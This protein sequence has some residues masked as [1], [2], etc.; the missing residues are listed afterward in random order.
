MP[1]DMEFQ[2]PVNA[3]RYLDIL[4]DD[5]N[6]VKYIMSFFQS[7]IVGPP[8]FGRVAS[9]CL[10]SM[11]FLLGASRLGLFVLRLLYAFRWN[12]DPF[13]AWGVSVSDVGKFVPRNLP[14]HW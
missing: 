3:Q 9:V 6:P 11:T 7:G 1:H 8:P 2:Y 14:R 4:E 10:L 12:W 13:S 5:T